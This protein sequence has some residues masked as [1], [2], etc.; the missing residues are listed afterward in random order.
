MVPP[1]A[2]LTREGTSCHLTRSRSVSSFLGGGAYP[3]AGALHGIA[4]PAR[5]SGGEARMRVWPRGGHAPAFLMVIELMSD[6]H[7]VV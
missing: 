5:R 3:R 1:V 7:L 6:E 4:G 2:G